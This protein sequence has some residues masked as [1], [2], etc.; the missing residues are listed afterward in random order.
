MRP[1]TLSHQEIILDRAVVV[2][3]GGPLA[4]PHE[5]L[6]ETVPWGGS[7]PSKLGVYPP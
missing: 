4:A 2:Q 5:K 3:P 1:G 7:A 6:I